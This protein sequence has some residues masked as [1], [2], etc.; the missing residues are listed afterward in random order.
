MHAETAKQVALL[1]TEHNKLPRPLNA[2]DVLKDTTIIVGVDSVK[3]I[4]WATVQLRKAMWCM[5]EMRHL[6]VDPSRRRKGLGVELIRQAEAHAVS[7]NT[8]IIVATVRGD[9]DPM[10]KLLSKTGY[11]PITTF[12]NNTTSN[13]VVV[14]SKTITIPKKDE[15]NNVSNSS[16]NR[17][18]SFTPR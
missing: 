17:Y 14:W 2:D 8:P 5:L 1:V 9:N 12:V 7:I 10:T 13:V 11:T 18:G 6:T 3:P 15:K 16:S 4:V